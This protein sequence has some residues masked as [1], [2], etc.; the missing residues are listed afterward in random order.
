MRRKVS[1]RKRGAVLAT[2]FLKRIETET[3]WKTDWEH[4]K[5]Q[6]KQYDSDI[7]TTATPET[8][9]HI[10]RVENVRENWEMS[11]PR[12]ERRR[13]LDRGMVN[14]LKV[15][16]ER[17]ANCIQLVHAVA[18]V[19]QAVYETPQDLV[20]GENMNRH[21]GVHIHRVAQ[22]GGLGVTRGS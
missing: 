17:M 21:R 1:E 6:E 14:G 11:N 19:V 8:W 18:P 9:S 22:A 3:T 2:R 13:A 4:V 10:H 15:T 20:E 7:T 12:F 16:L 5:A